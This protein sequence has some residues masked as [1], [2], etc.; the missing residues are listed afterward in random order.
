MLTPPPVQSPS[1]VQISRSMVSWLGSFEPFRP[2]RT[3]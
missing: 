3:R 2:N 1:L